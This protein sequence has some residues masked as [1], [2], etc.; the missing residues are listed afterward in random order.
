MNEVLQPKYKLE[1]N[2]NTICGHNC[3]YSLHQLVPEE[4]NVGKEDW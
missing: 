4:L 3:T 1:K 2:N